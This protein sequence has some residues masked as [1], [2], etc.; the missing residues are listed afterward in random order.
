[1]KTAYSYTLQSTIF[2]LD[3]MACCSLLLTQLKD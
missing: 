2:R 1:M 3:Q